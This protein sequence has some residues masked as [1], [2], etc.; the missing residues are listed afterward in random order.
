MT[1]FRKYG[2]Q[3]DYPEGWVVQEQME[4]GE[5]MVTVS[6][7]DSSFWSLGLFFDSPSP[8][9]V[10]QTVL[11]AFE[12]D[13]PEID[14]YESRASI[15]DRP[16]VSRDVEFVCMELLNS[17]WIRAFQTERF[18]VLVLYQSTDYE[19]PES[20]SILDAVTGSLDIDLDDSEDR[21]WIPDVEEDDG[22]SD[23]DHSCNHSH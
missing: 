8:E 9:H 7:P 18:T 4:G 12:E 2:V 19:L 1:I 21:N 13:Y 16:T 14:V 15:L 6:S 23:I 3:F 20:E 5:W 22:D 10:V 17:A 11:R